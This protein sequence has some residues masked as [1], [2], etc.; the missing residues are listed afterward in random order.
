MITC[1]DCGALNAADATAC[2]Q[3]LDQQSRDESRRRGQWMRRL[4][5][6]LDPDKTNL[7]VL[8]DGGP[9][10]RDGAASDGWLV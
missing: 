3:C 4:E 2:R 6:S 9:D 10:M 7:P 1:I 5:A 8:H